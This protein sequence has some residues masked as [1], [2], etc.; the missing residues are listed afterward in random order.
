MNRI[1]VSYFKFPAGFWMCWFD[2]HNKFYVFTGSKKKDLVPQIRSIL[3]TGWEWN[4]KDR[5]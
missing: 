5:N 4:K 1:P 2:Y 3:G